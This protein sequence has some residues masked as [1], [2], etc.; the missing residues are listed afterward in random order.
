MDDG[1]IKYNNQSLGKVAIWMIWILFFYC[2]NIIR[3]LRQ[4]LHRLI[5]NIAIE[6][7]MHKYKYKKPGI[8]RGNL[9]TYELSTANRWSWF[10]NYI[11]SYLELRIKIVIS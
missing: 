1:F 8:C 2:F 7:S 4:K 6:V 3:E 11:I 9:V 10:I 5:K